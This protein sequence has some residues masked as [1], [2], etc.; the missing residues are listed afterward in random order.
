MACAAAASSSRTSGP[1]PTQAS[2]GR[3]RHWRD[4]TG[5][6][7]LLHALRIGWAPTCPSSHC[8]L[9]LRDIHSGVDIS[10][11]ATT[12]PTLNQTPTALSQTRFERTAAEA[13]T[14]MQNGAP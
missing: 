12:E 10:R 9:A 8:T 6:T 4:N 14:T 7:A 2:Q 11:N 3:V 13:A 5:E 1:F